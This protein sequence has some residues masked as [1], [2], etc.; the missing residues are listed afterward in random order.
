M[1]INFDIVL[2]YINI[3]II[4]LVCIY[5]AYTGV[6]QNYRANIDSLNTLFTLPTLPKTITT[7]T[8]R[9]QFTNK[10][11]YSIWL[12]TLREKKLITRNSIEDISSENNRDTLDWVKHGL[13]RTTLGSWHEPFADKHHSQKLLLPYVYHIP[14]NGCVAYMFVFYS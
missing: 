11:I 8:L 7:H 10:Y 1:Y 2:R 4:L 9:E 12:Y 3:I 13:Q 6:N 14:N 5:F